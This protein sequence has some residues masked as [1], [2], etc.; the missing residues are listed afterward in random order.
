MHLFTNLIAFSYAAGILFFCSCQPGSQDF[1]RGN[2]NQDKFSAYWYKGE[3][4]INSYDLQQ[5]RYGE[6]REGEAVMIFVSEDM[7]KAK[8]VKL[9]N[10]QDAGSDRIPVLKLNNIHRFVTGIYDYSLMESVFTP[11]N[12]GEYPHSLKTTTTSQDW[13]GH[14]FIQLNLEGGKYRIAGYSYFE[15]E[16][17]ETTLI[18]SAML[19]DELWCRLRIDPASIREGEL[20]LIPGSFYARLQHQPLRPR[21]ARVRFEE[22]EGIKFLI[23]E[24]LHI[25]RTLSIGFEPGFPHKILSWTE[26]NG[27]EITSQGTIKETLKSAYWQQNGKGFEYLRDSLRLR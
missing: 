14:S 10:P 18:D 9:D 1:L 7:S 6:L 3:A 27:K 19:E 24:Y 5:T 17:D 20:E 26:Q 25:D 11:V 22:R 13:C 4:E 16:G 8:Q 2:P 15:Q 23:V 12:I 21:K